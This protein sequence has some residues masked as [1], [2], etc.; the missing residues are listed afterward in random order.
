VLSRI[1]TQCPC[2]PGVDLCA[3]GKRRARQL[4]RN[5]DHGWCHSHIG[6]SKP[7]SAV[8]LFFDE[9]LNPGVASAHS[10]LGDP[11]HGWL[12]SPSMCGRVKS[13]TE[14]KGRL[15][16]VVC[17]IHTQ[18]RTGVEAGSRDGSCRARPVLLYP[19][20]VCRPQ[21]N[22]TVEPIVPYQQSN[23]PGSSERLLEEQFEG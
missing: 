5:I 16:V 12:I 10:A 20:L 18:P 4:G 22:R 14:S 23:Q 17:E 7:V 8:A 13:D 15:S 3:R 9:F 19:Y 11:S 2:W 1:W 6:F 21:K